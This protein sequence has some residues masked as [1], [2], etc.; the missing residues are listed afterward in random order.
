MS[1]K[2]IRWK[3]KKKSWLR[4]SNKIGKIVLL[5]DWIC[6]RWNRGEEKEAQTTGRGEKKGCMR[7]WLWH[8]INKREFLRSFKNQTRNLKSIL[9][10]LRKQLHINYVKWFL[11]ITHQSFYVTELIWSLGSLISNGIKPVP[12]RGHW[13]GGETFNWHQS[14]PFTAKAVTWRSGSHS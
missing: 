13:K 2:G 1:K 9:K 10:T 4:G 8:E 7:I 12:N 5:W 14:L 3:R 11:V 6:D